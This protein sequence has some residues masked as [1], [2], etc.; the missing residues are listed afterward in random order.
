MEWLKKVLN[1]LKTQTIS[2]AGVLADYITTQIGLTKGFIETHP[3]YTPINALVIFT[4]VNLIIA[5]VKCNNKW[6][7]AAQYILSAVVWYGAIN[8]IC[9]LVGIL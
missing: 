6:H 1:F 8:N 3:Q 5:I 2:I 4:L 7:N 9:V